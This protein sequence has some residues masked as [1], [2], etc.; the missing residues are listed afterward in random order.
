[1]PINKN[2]DKFKCEYETYYLDGKPITYK[3]YYTNRLNSKFS[4]DENN[5]VIL[6]AG[7]DINLFKSVKTFF[8]KS[9][10]YEIKAS[11]KTQDVS[12][13]NTNIKFINVL[14]D[15]Y[16]IKIIPAKT[17]NK[18]EVIGNKLYLHLTNNDKK[19]DLLK[20][21]YIFLAKPYVVKRVK[22]WRIKMGAKI[23]DILFKSMVT[24]CAYYKHSNNSITFSLQ[25]LSLN[26]KAFDYLIIHEIA[27]YFQQNHSSAFWNIVKTYCP[28]YKEY[29]KQFIGI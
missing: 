14:G 12:W 29:E 28:N 22:Y 26:K 13:F 9:L 21:A 3:V 6:L 18:F 1:M 2:L 20:K 16:E 19:E 7:K 8:E 17:N 25:S 27:H 24:I 23:K 15:K 5:E 10:S 11:K 4:L